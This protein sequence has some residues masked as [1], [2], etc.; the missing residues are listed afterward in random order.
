MKSSELARKESAFAHEQF[1]ETQKLDRAAAQRTWEAAQNE[2]QGYLEF[3]RQYAID[4]AKFSLQQS[5]NSLEYLEEDLRQLERMYEEDELT[6][7]SEELVLIRARRAIESAKFRLRNTEVRTE[8]TLQQSL[9]REIKNRQATYQR[10]KLAYGR[11]IS[12]LEIARKK[13]QIEIETSDE[14]FQ[15]EQEKLT[16]LRADGDKLVIE[17]PAKGLVLYGKLNRGQLADKASTMQTGTKIAKDQTILTIVNPKR[18]RIRCTVAEK[19]ISQLKMGMR[20]RVTPTSQPNQVLDAT[21][22]SLNR[23]PFAKGKYDCVLS[24]KG[25]PKAILPTMTCSIEF[26]PDTKSDSV[27]QPRKNKQKKR[28]KEPGKQASKKE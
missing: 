13:K 24:I 21:I 23:V 11:S 6:E 15:E 22:E 9:P 7:E 27:S 26:E 1:M 10:A 17:S 28:K 18:L 12:D 3:D 25:T 14:A 16:E 8:R 19:D 20:G 2:Y 4:S 5:R